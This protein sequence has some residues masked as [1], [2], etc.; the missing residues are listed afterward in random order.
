MGVEGGGVKMLFEC[1]HHL[2]HFSNILC[3]GIILSQAIA[4]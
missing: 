2:L 1:E 4:L 3:M